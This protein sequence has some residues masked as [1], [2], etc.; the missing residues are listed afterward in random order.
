MDDGETIAE[1]FSFDQTINSVFAPIPRTSINSAIRREQSFQ[2][3]SGMTAPET[4]SRLGRQLGARYIVA[5]TITNLGT[6]RLL[7][8]SI[9]RIDNLQQIA[10]DWRSYTDIGEI[11]DKLPEM[12]RD[13]IASSRKNTSRLPRLAVLPFQTPRG[14]REA[15]ALSQILAVEIVRS[16]TY[17]V[18]PRTKTLE[19]IQTEYQNQ[20]N[21]DT[22]DD[23]AI[24]IGRGDNPLL[25]L[26]GAVR[27]L[28]SNR[29]MFNVAIINVESGVQLKGDTVNYNTIEEGVEAIWALS[30]KLASIEYI[31]TNSDS[32]W[33]T[34]ST[35]DG[36]G[37][38]NYTIVLN[39]NINTAGTQRNIR[40][41]ANNRKLI[42][43]RGD[44]TE[45]IITNG[46]NSTLIEVPSGVT[47]ILGNNL[48]LN[49]NNIEQSIISILGGGTL[50]METG[51]TVTGARDTGIKIG[52]ELGDGTGASFTMNGG[53]ISNNKARRDGGGV[54]VRR[55]TIFS[56][57]GGT[58]TGNE[59]NSPSNAQG[60]GGVYVV[61]KFI[62]SGGNI[63]NNR[64]EYGGGISIPET[65]DG[66]FIK[67]GG[68]I[69]KN[70][71]GHEGRQVYTLFIGVKRNRAAGPTD[72]LETSKYGSSGEWE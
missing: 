71:A 66:I 29:R 13:I 57:T 60:G 27:S 10:G 3:S 28:G 4:I 52:G 1:L 68:T 62:M 37:P 33:R 43:I 5:G 14:D 41:A 53:T 63:I 9:M 8:I 46:N 65:N 18:Y 30:S 48:Q 12:A 35:I 19:Q 55:G 67:T 72:N 15:D 20:Y 32:F 44:G 25:A 58:I 49:G 26:S 64:A 17:A 22:A 50:R 70:Y 36:A 2:M 51:A 40:F 61:G 45:R 42:T 59:S 38:G 7:V 69:E 24:V 56:M 31:V 54:R 21:G 6:Q 34:L 16:G 39:C 11:Q 23:Q 47:L